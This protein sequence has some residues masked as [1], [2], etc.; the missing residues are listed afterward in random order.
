M[1][2][3]IAAGHPAGP[4]RAWRL[5]RGNGIRLS[6]LL[7]GLPGLFGTL[8]AS[9][10]AGNLWL[11]MALELVPTPYFALVDLGILAA[12]YRT[13]SDQPLSAHPRWAPGPG[14][15]RTASAALAPAAGILTMGVVAALW[16]PVPPPVDPVPARTGVTAPANRAP[17]QTT[18][19]YEHHGEGE[20]LTAA[21]ERV[22]LRYVVTWRVADA[23]RYARTTGADPVRAANRIDEFTVNQLRGAVARLTRDRLLERVDEPGSN[24]SEA[25]LRSSRLTTELLGELNAR[26]HQFGVQATGWRVESAAG[27]P[28]APGRE[29]TASMASPESVH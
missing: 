14:P 17:V 22:G 16:G 12:A 3:A 19:D 29:T 11:G 5:S 24:G 18:D 13:L 15:A 8:L 10:P 25:G 2:P 1:L 6:V 28:P 21:K 26:M 7:F 4:G 27:A 20:F 23:D 9:L